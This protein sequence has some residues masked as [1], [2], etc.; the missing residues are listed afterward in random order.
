VYA[1][2]GGEPIRVP[3]CTAFR[4]ASAHPRDSDSSHQPKYLVCPPAARKLWALCNSLAPSIRVIDFSESFFLPFSG[5]ILPGIPRDF[6]APELLLKLPAE[7]SQGIDI[8]ALGCIIYE[9]LGSTCLFYSM[10]DSLSYQIADIVAVLGGK[11]ALPER[12]RDAFRESGAPRPLEDDD[13]DDEFERLDWDGRMKILPGEPE[14][15]AD[16]DQLCEA[17]EAV[18]KKVL[19]EA[20][21]I[22][23]A[24]RATA[25]AI[26]AMMPEAWETMEASDDPDDDDG[27]SSPRQQW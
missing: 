23:P 12:F 2:L 18:M 6:A 4:Y 22:E 26:V 11:E 10:W 21:V 9:L 5:Q 1:A 27:E 3:L 15:F 14:E 20:M 19:G 16:V 8:W 7:V 25:E 17:D 24:N 13:D